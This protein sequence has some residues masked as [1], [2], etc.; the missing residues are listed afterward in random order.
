MN[1]LRLRLSEV[2]NENNSLHQVAQETNSVMEEKVQLS[3]T[4]AQLTAENES[5]LKENEYFKE[6][7]VPTMR[8]KNQEM[9]KKFQEFDEE[10]KAL[11]KENQ[12]MKTFKTD[13]EQLEKER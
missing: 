12:R 13:S 3:S 9:Q 1:E 7:L 2:E 5:L 6:D 4:L 11:K 10:R 8:A